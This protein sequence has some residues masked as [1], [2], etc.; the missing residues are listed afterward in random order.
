[1]QEQNSN[2]NRGIFIVLE[3]TDRSGKTTQSKKI[4]DYLISIGRK[5]VETKFPDRST[6]IGKMLD[7]YLGKSIKMAPQV[8]HLLFTANRWELN[9]Y[10]KENLENGIDVVCDRYS[11]SGIAYSSGA[12]NLD[13]EWCKS[14][15]QGLISPDIVVFLEVNLDLSSTRSGFGVEI[16]ENISDQISVRK[17]Y[18]KFSNYSFWRNINASQSPDDVFKEIVPH[19]EQVFQNIKP[20]SYLWDED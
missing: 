19:I 7:G 20:I 11:F 12:I 4:Y 8:S 10:I 2:K 16:Y 3:G 1:M 6:N 9:N 17:V 15:E 13:F 14:R 5:C 18:Q